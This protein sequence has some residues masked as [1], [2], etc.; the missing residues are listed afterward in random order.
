MLWPSLQNR[1]SEVFPLEDFR[2]VIDDFDD[3]GLIL[4]RRRGKKYRAE[5]IGSSADDDFVTFKFFSPQNEKVETAFS[6]ERE[7][8]AVDCEAVDFIC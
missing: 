6:P 8:L 3:A 4:F 2:L 7:C 5:A 1:G